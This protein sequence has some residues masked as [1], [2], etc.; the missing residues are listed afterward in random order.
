M[1]VPCIPM[2]MRKTRI[3]NSLRQSKWQTSWM[4]A[5]RKSAVSHGSGRISTISAAAMQPPA[6]TDKSTGN[7]RIMGYNMFTEGVERISQLMAIAQVGH[8]SAES[9]L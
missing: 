2:R 6:E 3:M 8:K 1:A 9:R 7:G 5:A 4:A